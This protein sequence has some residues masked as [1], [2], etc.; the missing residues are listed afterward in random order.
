[1]IDTPILEI[2]YDVEDIVRSGSSSMTVGQP[3]ASK[4]SSFAA[5]PIITVNL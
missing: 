3:A 2:P 4:T 5:L 1:M